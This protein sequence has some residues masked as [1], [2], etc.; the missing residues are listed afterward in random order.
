MVCR[1]DLQSSPFVAASFALE[2]FERE[3][4]KQDMIQIQRDMKIDEL[5]ERKQNFLSLFYYKT[6]K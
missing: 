1:M 2:E 6:I 3:S 5:L 4:I